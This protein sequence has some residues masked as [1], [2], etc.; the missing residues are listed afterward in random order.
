MR[1]SDRSSAVQFLFG[2]SFYFPVAVCEFQ[3]RSFSS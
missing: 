2:E 3:E 1:E